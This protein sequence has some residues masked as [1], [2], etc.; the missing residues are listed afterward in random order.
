MQEEACMRRHAGGGMQEE[1]CRRRVLRLAFAPCLALPFSLS[2][3]HTH[4]EADAA[5]HE[6]MDALEVAICANYWVHQLA[7][8]TPTCLLP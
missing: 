5:W 3:T 1:A 6:G 2:H 8:S 7:S 4:I